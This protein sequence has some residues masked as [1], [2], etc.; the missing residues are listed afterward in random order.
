MSYANKRGKYDAVEFYAS[1]K[2]R[3]DQDKL[4]IIKYLH[5]ACNLSHKPDNFKLLLWKL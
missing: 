1:L 3:R 2:A 4:L 5:R